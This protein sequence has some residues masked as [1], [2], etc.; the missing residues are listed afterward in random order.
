MPIVLN[1]V[2]DTTRTIAFDAMGD[3]MSAFLP[4]CPTPTISRTAKEIVTD[5]CQRGKVWQEDLTP[6]PLVVSQLNYA[7]VSPVS[8]AEVTDVTDASTLVTG[9][10]RELV[11]RSYSA[12]KRQYPNWPDNEPG[13]AQF[14]TARTVG[15]VLL[16]PVP[17]VAGT[18]NLRGY[19][20]PTAT[21][22]VWDADLYAEFSREVFHG[23]LHKLMMMPNRSWTDAK[24]AMYHGK[25]WTYLLSCARIR[26][27]KAYNVDDTAVEMRPF[28]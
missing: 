8:Y 4:G 15:E 25:Q 17:D 9:R 3:D 2:V 11:L 26:A 18:L 6:L 20:R 12:V 5:L 16:A 1:P 7:P 23:V 22:D 10:K 21:A 13:D 28:A 19:L 27:T 14:Y 24:T